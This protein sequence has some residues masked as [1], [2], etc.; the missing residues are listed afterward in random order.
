MRV[1]NDTCIKSY[2]LIN[3][4]FLSDE[5]IGILIRKIMIED[6]KNELRYEYADE[7]TIKATNSE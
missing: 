1:K 4:M 7:E 3:T 6:D 5:E 2:Q